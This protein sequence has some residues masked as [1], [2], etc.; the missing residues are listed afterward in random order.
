MEK[1]EPIYEVVI[2]AAGDY[3]TAGKALRLLQTADRVV[4][5]DS[6]A[7]DFIRREGRYP[8]RIVGDCDSLPADLCQRYADIIVHERE[9][10][11]NDLSK[12]IRFVRSEGFNRIA[13][14][15]ATG[16]RED[17]TLGNISL[18]IDYMRM[19]LEVSMLTDYGC[20]HPCH[21]SFSAELPLGT[22]VSIF[23]FGATGFRGNGLRYPLHDFTNWWQGTLNETVQPN[24]D[25][26]A[27]GD[28]LVYVC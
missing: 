3:P 10:E 27:Q 14:V 12:A 22:Q 28:F 9:Q 16:K 5:C 6:A 17:H 23:S 18:L 26:T 21:D 24:I 8:W 25:I 1:K 19:G 15:G 13:I 11:T 2:L 20:F 4:C 7:A